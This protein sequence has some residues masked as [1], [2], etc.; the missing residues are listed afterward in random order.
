MGRYAF[1]STGYEYK[2]TFGVQESEDILTFGGWKSLTRKE[3]EES[4]RVRWFAKEDL[5]FIRTRLESFGI[6]LLNLANYDKSMNDLHRFDDDLLNSV[7]PDYNQRIIERTEENKSRACFR[8]GCLI[9]FQ[10]HM[11]PI[12][13]VE[14]EY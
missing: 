8:L 1:F 13:D 9:Y 3:D 4:G 6:P 10:L 2:F 5:A 11:V 7:Y 14:F 12:L